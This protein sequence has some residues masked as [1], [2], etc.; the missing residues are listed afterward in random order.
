[1]DN[2]NQEEVNSNDEGEMTFPPDFNEVSPQGEDVDENWWVECDYCNA[3]LQLSDEELSQGWYICPECDQLSHLADA[4][5]ESVEPVLQFPARDDDAEWV[6]LSEVT[7]AE[8]ASLVVSYL[9]SNGIEAFAWQEGAGRAFG[10]TIGMLGATH[11]MVRDD[12]AQLAHS[13]LEAEVEKDS[14]DYEP[15]DESLAD[16]SKAVMGLVAVTISPI[17]AGIAFGLSQVLG[18]Q[19]DEDDQQISLVECIYCSESLELSEEEVAQG[20]YVCPECQ[21]LV[22]LRDYVTCP[23]CQTELALGEAEKRQGWYRCPECDQ[24]TQL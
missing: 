16:T 1:M 4:S 6:Q 21:R 9:Q 3:E 19:D 17:G 18:Q 20:H 15:T 12:Q 22:R 14:D 2:Q 10:L 24:E 11:V 7:G 8:E 5:G 23:S 13:V